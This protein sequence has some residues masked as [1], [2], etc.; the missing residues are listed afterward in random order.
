MFET[1]P[2][3]VLPSAQTCLMPLM[4]PG[5]SSVWQFRS[6]VW[7]VWMKLDMTGFFRHSRKRRVKG[8]LPVSALGVGGLEG[9]GAGTFDDVD[10]C[11]W[12]EDDLGRSLY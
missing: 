1:F 10:E 2:N 6:S 9:I 3:K 11:A 12:V 7:F 4:T 8:N 5:K